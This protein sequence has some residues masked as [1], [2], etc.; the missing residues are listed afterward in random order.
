MPL[1]RTSQLELLDRIDGAIATPALAGNLR[2]IRRA[3]RW[4]GG[5]RA[6]LGAVLPVIRALGANGATVAILDLATGS[7]DIPAAILDRA[8][9]EKLA[10]TILATDLEP[11]ILAEAR[12][13]ERP[14]LR[15]DV[16]DARS[17]PYSDAAFD[18]VLLSLALHHFEPEDAVPV[19]AEMRRVGRRALIV[20]DLERS[21][22]GL[23][24]AWLFGNALTRNPMTRH[25][26]PLSVR[27]AYTR[28]EARAMA[29][30]AGWADIS[31]RTVVPF[32]YL[33]RGTPS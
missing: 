7:A 18:I 30:A 33:L 24:G 3:N 11:H 2:D 19:L 6:M 1:T 21:R 16:A 4:F 25:D 9:R 12:A 31:T 27:R 20:N 32:R 26:A 10:V 14:G 8:E 5:T 23:A 29:R 13:V 17:L 28:A 22:V 15:L